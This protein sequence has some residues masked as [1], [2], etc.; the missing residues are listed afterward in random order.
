MPLG[1]TEEI[2]ARQPP[3]AQ[4][5]IRGLLAEI[6]AL[7]ARIEKLERQVKGKTPQNS[8]LP[9]S[10][11]HPH[12]R[13]QPPKRKS[14]KKR[15]GQP[16]HEKHERP[17]IPSAQCDDV[18]PLRPTECRRCGA[19]LSGNDPE[20]LR[21][22]VWEVP[23]IQ[24]IV[25][26]YQRHRLRCPCCGETTCAELPLGVPQGQ[27]GPRLMAFV[28]LLMAF[29]RQSKRRTAEFLS[30]LLGQPCSASLSV[31]IQNQV[32]TALRPSYEALAAQLPA[33]EQLNIDETGT[34]EANGK[35][36]L[37]TFVA[38]LFTV[39]AVRATREATALGAFLGETFQGIVTCDRA[40]MYW[41]VER[42]QWC[43]AHLKRDF[44][45]IIDGGDSRA[46]HLGQRLRRATCTLFEHWADYRG[47]RISRA[48]LLRRMGPVR[49]TVERLLLRGTRSGSRNVR[50][51]C[52]ELYEHRQWLW[53]FLS[54]EGVE[55]TDNAG[56][57]SLRHAVIWRKLSFGTQSA[58]GSRFVET[59][60]TVIETCRQQRHNVFAFLTAAVD[61]HLAHQPAPSLLTRV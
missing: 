11:Q 29:Y 59:M 46:K 43:W 15:G 49:R 58:S 52:R 54:H 7:K 41:Q 10:T 50:G 32:T 24:P 53:T 27:S 31:K 61:S 56:E 21:H 37:W 13:P 18:L 55:P 5:I 25:T 39:F 33:Q 34:K 2:I 9:P 3:E 19:K 22:Q 14:K 40:K 48:A 38:R 35:A 42:L 45:A 23:E 16:G 4:A 17:L 8:S 47:G 12:A 28:A 6:V 60:L 44:Q 57:R 36:W 30:T 51:T 26:E 20:P 1:I